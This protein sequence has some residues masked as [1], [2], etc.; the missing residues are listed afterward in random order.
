MGGQSISGTSG[1]RLGWVAGGRALYYT[2]GHA[3]SA[4]PGDIHEALLVSET[5]PGNVYG[6]PVCYLRHGHRAIELCL[7]ESLGPDLTIIH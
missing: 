5:L 1:V 2:I 3:D 6:T 7:V 4:V